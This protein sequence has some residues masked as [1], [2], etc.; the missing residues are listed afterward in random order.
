MI[1]SND[2]AFLMLKPIFIKCFNFKI[3]DFIEQKN[4]KKFEK[5]FEKTKK[6]FV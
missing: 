4:I 2:I 3:K 1:F 6:R 5:E